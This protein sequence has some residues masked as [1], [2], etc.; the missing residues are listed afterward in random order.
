MKMMQRKKNLGGK[1]NE[2][3]LDDTYDEP[4]ADVDEETDEDL[5]K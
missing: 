4:I 3:A 2:K 5:D 1:Y